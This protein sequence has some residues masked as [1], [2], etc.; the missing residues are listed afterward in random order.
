MILGL[1]AAPALAQVVD[2]GEVQSMRVN[3]V[4][5]TMMK[6]Q[7]LLLG[8]SAILV[9]AL[10]FAGGLLKPNGFK[11]AGLR[12]VSSMPAFVWLFA[13]F[14]VMLAMSSAPTLISKIQWVH[15]QNY[16]ALQLQ[17]VNTIGSY[18]FGIIAGIGMLFI[19]SR[20]APDCGLKLGFVDMPLGLG[21]FVLAFPFIQLMAIFG[22]FAYEQTQQGALPERIAHPTL[23]QLV[24]NSGDPWVWAIAAGAVIGAPIVE[25]LIY[26]VF[27]QGALLRW[28]KSPWLS[29]IFSA[30]IFAMMHRASS[31]PVPWHA[32]LPIFTLGLCCGVAYERTKRVG[33][34][35]TMHI[36]FNLLSVIIALTTQP[37]SPANPAG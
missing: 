6:W 30:I 18:L 28:L 20:G 10:L 14:V 5:E 35:I 15:D 22:V 1:F 33:V 7:L 37:G 29:I 27:L 26:R 23:Q 12:D 13:G 34:P 4:V 3:D 32:L 21:C 31:T 36:C 8:V 25:E 11:A 9:L 17:A 24:D 16:S 19:L 2:T